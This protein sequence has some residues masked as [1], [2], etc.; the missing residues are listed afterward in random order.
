MRLTQ[1]TEKELI[2]QL[3]NGKI[4]VPELQ[5]G[6]KLSYKD[7]RAL[8]DYALAQKWIENCHFGN[9]FTVIATDFTRKDITEEECKS[10]LETHRHFEIRILNCLGRIFS[11]KFSDILGNVPSIEN[12]L[13]NALNALVRADLVVEHQKIY[14]CK[15]TKKSV[16]MLME[17][18]ASSESIT[19]LRRYFGNPR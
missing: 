5:L 19:P 4:S 1:D 14:Y 9:E 12:E 7:A 16:E 10:I 6:M 17:R 8:I 13:K 11:A 18:D 3:S 2:T 15:L